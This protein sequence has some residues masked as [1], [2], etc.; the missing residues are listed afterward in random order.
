MNLRPLPPE[1][2]AHPNIRTVFGVGV[3]FLSSQ[4]D[5]IRF[6]SDRFDLHSDLHFSDKKSPAEAGLYI[7][8][9]T[10]KTGVLDPGPVAA[11]GKC[12]H[13]QFRLQSRCKGHSRSRARIFVLACCLNK[14]RGLWPLR[15]HRYGFSDLSLRH[16]LTPVPSP[17]E[18]CDKGSCSDSN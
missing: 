13:Q 11:S 6:V 16:H 18:D 3:E 10:L 14:N 12:S 1:V 15:S 7:R 4:S 5:L 2:R 9:R 17:L 8:K